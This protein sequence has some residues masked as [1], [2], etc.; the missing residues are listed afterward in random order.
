MNYAMDVVPGSNPNKVGLFFH[1]LYR[2][3]PYPLIDFVV[4]Y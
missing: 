1:L 2:N 3:A 4:D